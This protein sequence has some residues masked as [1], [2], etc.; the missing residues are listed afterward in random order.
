MEGAAEDREIEITL[1]EELASEQAAKQARL[2]EEMEQARL[3]ALSHRYNVV[4]NRRQTQ[5]LTES[6]KNREKLYAGMDFRTAIRMNTMKA[7]IKA[8][9]LDDQPTFFEK[10]LIDLMTDET[11]AW[12][13]FLQP[14]FGTWSDGIKRASL[15][16]IAPL[17]VD[18]YKEMTLDE[19]RI[20]LSWLENVFR[21]LNVK[22]REA[23][24]DEVYTWYLESYLVVAGSREYLALNQKLVKMI[25]LLH[26]VVQ[27]SQTCFRE[28]RRQEAALWIHENTDNTDPSA[29]PLEVRSMSSHSH[30]TDTVND[31]RSPS[32]PSYFK[33]PELEGSFTQRTSVSNPRVAS[34]GMVYHD[35]AEQ[36]ADVAPSIKNESVTPSRR[37]SAQASIGFLMDYSKATIRPLPLPWIDPQALEAYKAGPSEVHECSQPEEDEA[38]HFKMEQITNP[39]TTSLATQIPQGTQGTPGDMGKVATLG[40]AGTMKTSGITCRRWDTKELCTC[41]PWILYPSSPAAKTTAR[42]RING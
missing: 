16:A 8:M 15:D 42:R 40:T 13:K 24:D 1:K 17:P 36:P 29:P 39:P 14:E 27:Y 33:K 37:S 2:K 6:F 30:A 7:R 35:L 41:Y 11:N 25:S 28:S 9:P 26:Y 23:E 34:R 10:E 20:C 5:I 19:C 12:T 38:S 32:L 22:I 21:M 31:S 3:S 18:P 4:S